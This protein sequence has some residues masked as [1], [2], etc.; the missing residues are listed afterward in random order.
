MGVRRRVVGGATIS[1]NWN[2]VLRVDENKTTL[3]DSFWLAVLLLGLTSTVN[4]CDLM[5]VCDN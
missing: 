4:M 1:R 2:S 5:Q 3:F